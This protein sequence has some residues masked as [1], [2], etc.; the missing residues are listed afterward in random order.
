VLRAPSLRVAPGL[1]L[2]WTGAVPV[3]D[4]AVVGSDTV[5]PLADDYATVPEHARASLVGLPLSLRG[6]GDVLVVGSSSWSTPAMAAARELTW[7]EPDRRLTQLARK[8]GARFDAVTDSPYRFMTTT[9]R[10]FSLI[11][12]DGAFAAG[13][14]A[15]ED[16]ILTT[17]GLAAA[18]ER[19]DED[20]LLAIGMAIEYPPRQGPRLMANLDAALKRIGAGTPGDRVAAVRGMQSMLVLVG[21]QPLA[22]RDIAQIRD[23]TEQ[24]QFDQVWLPGMRSDRA[25]RNH[26]LDEPVFHRAAAAVFDGTPMP[27]AA[28]WFETAP[29][30]VQRPYFWRAMQWTRVP[31]MF[32]QLGQRAASLLDWTLVMSALAMVIVTL[33]AAVLILAPLGRLPR[34]QRPFGK[35]SVGGYF[36][37]LGLGFMLVELAVFQR[38]IM[39]LDRPVLSASVVFALFLIGAGIGSA[40]PPRNNAMPR[41]FAALAIGGTVTII[42]L[43]LAADWLLTLPLGLRIAALALVMLPMT[44]AMGRPFPW[45][46]GQLSAQPGW[47]PWGWGINAFASVTA[48]S[49]APLVS[50]QFGQP[51]TLLVGVFCY[52]GAWG[53]ARRWVLGGVERGPTR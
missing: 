13:D 49:A 21:R 34:L 19:L 26:V 31:E 17:G 5:V 38:A 24:W 43:R 41:I 46:L 50:V 35:L 12:L 7:L 30:T 48:A 22:A 32:D 52:L 8:R 11:S 47:L 23:F 10:R 3:V 1:S 36:L 44:W 18:L 14:A 29:A 37:G 28:R 15:S 2:S 51:A 39:F 6:A 42:A 33:L 20:G 27:A 45:A 25:N 40:M 16:Y 53:I 9:D 4:A